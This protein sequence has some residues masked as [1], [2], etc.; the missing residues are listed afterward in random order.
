MLLYL[1]YI[2]I[3]THRRDLYAALDVDASASKN[4]ILQ[5]YRM[6]SKKFHPDKVAAAVAVGGTPP[7]RP[8]GFKG[9][10][11]EEFF[12]E[13]RR[14]QE[15]LM[16]DTRKS[17]YDRFGDYKYG[18]V[19]EKTTIIVVCLAVV[20]HLL[21]FCVGFLVS[22]PKHV[23]FA[24]QIYVVYNLAMF[25]NELQIRFV[26]D[27]DS[28]SFL[29]YVNKLAPFARVHFFRSVFPCVLCGSLC[30]SSWNFTDNPTKRLA[31]LKAL[32]S[33]NRVL[34]ERTQELIRVTAYLKAMGT[35]S[36]ANIKLQQQQVTPLQSA[37]LRLK[38]L[39]H[40][41]PA[42]S[43]D[44]GSQ[45]AGEDDSNAQRASTGPNAK[46]MPPPAS[47]T[48]DKKDVAEWEDFTNTLNVEQKELFKRMV[49]DQYRK[50]EAEEKAREATRKR[51]DINW[52][53][54]LMW[55]CVLYVWIYYK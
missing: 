22:F 35:P 53:Q 29:P 38:A 39:G 26:E 1:F 25:C 32:L 34:T 14:A 49:A 24:R 43:Q 2:V 5:A 19:D 41:V 3:P 8:P 46:R 33:T 45:E 6:V 30:L 40:D 23:T 17:N 20:A 48:K 28:L 12:M 10:T 36:T 31:L 4:D 55:S 16:S 7:Q 52:S 21:C 42:P 44:S 13:I 15:V 11:N 47:N 51:F 9:M 54:A 50:A 27:G 37:A 18:D